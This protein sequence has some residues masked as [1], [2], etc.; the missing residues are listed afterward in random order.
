MPRRIRSECPS[1]RHRSPRTSTSPASGILRPSKISTVVVL[2]APFGPSMPKHSPARTS[3][4]RPSTAVTSAY[5]LTRPRQRRALVLTRYILADRSQG[6]WRQA[7]LVLHARR[8]RVPVSGQ[9]E[10][11]RVFFFSLF[12]RGC[13]ECCDEHVEV[14][15]SVSGRGDGGSHAGTRAGPCAGS[16]PAGVVWRCGHRWHP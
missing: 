5:R 15:K 12:L 2:P 10:S 8:F 4:S 6:H 13:D 7:C 3:R 1:P 9:P 11:G 16:A 14:D